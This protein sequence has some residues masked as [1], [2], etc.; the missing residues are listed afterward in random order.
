M[1][2]PARPKR[3]A[4]APKADARPWRERLHPRNLGSPFTEG[5]LLRWVIAVGLGG[6]LL[7]FLLITLLF[8][9]GFGRSP[10]V[11]VPDVRGRTLSA[12]ERALE[13]VGLELERGDSLPN[14]RIAK[15]RVLAQVPLPGSEAT[16]GSEVRVVISRG[17]EMRPVPSIRGLSLL[18]AQAA[19][20]RMGFGVRLL[21]VQNP[22]EEGAILGMKPQ[23][24]QLLAVG[25]SVEITLSAGPPKVA[26]PEIV[27]LTVADAGPRVQAV[28]LRIGA[29]SYDS[30]SLSTPGT[31]LSQR[32]AAGDSL[33]QGRGVRVTVAGRDPNPPPPPAPDSVPPETPPEEEPPAEPEPAEPPR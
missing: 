15:G 12:A 21:R 2:A 28:G 33:A 23:A 14:P 19:I 26:V 9:P 7:G 5:R 6:F 25:D 20:A 8:F 10:I 18:Q 24:G 11:T 13:R 4:R 1:K 16:R 3:P 27:G 22:E 30:A 31:I 32:P 29:V 17:P